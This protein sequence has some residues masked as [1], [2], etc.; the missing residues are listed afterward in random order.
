MNDS[1]DKPSLEP[2]RNNSIVAQGYY[3]RNNLFPYQE[4]L[5]VNQNGMTALQLAVEHSVDR[6]EILEIASALIRNGGRPE[7]EVNI[8]VVNIYYNHIMQG[9][10]DYINDPDRLNRLHQRWE[11]DPVYQQLRAEQVA[12][13]EVNNQDQEDT[14]GDLEEEENTDN[15]DV[16]CLNCTIL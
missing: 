14:L 5:L 1:Q 3:T 8:G 6:R 16:G 4:Q 7:G 11:E 13:G 2:N 15:I 9:L 12:R 10:R